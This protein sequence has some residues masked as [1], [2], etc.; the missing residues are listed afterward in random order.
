MEELEKRGMFSSL[1]GLIQ[2]QSSPSLMH[3]LCEF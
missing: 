3:A 2:P 1:T